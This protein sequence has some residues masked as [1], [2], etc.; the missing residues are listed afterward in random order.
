MAESSTPS[1]AEVQALL[2]TVA[3]F[4]RQ[5]HRLGPETQLVLA[6]FVEELGKALEHQEI[7]AAEIGRL[8][9]CAA[10]LLDAVHGEEPGVLD[11]ARVG[12][13]R[14]VVAVETRVPT[15]AGLLRR[16]A[17]TLADLGI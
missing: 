2:T 7:S 10:H 6:D 12:L 13:E 5:A 17:E 3:Q 1:S 15:V 16:L 4:L 9:D 14:A 8:T 11:S